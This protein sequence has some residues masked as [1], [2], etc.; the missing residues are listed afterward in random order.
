MKVFVK[1]DTKPTVKGL[2]CYDD[3]VLGF[4]RQMALTACIHNRSIK[5]D[6]PIV[7]SRML[8]YSQEIKAE[9]DE[10]NL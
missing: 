2:E 6:M 1:C 10:L 3:V 4:V 8:E 5:D 9:L 7:L